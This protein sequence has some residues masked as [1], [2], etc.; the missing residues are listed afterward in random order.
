M[1]EPKHI[2]PPRPDLD[3]VLEYM[4]ERSESELVRVIAA[5]FLHLANIAEDVAAEHEPME[6]IEP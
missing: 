3:L 4:S 2:P 1:S 5:G 6:D